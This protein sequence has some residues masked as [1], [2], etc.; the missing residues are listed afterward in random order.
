MKQFS[1]WHH[2]SNWCCEVHLNGWPVQG[3]TRYSCRK[4]VAYKQGLNP[5]FSTTALCVLFC[6]LKDSDRS[7][8]REKCI[9]GSGAPLMKCLGSYG[10]FG[11]TNSTS[12][13][14]GSLIFRTGRGP[15]L[16]YRKQHS[17]M[18]NKYSLKNVLQ[19]R[20]ERTVKVPFS[21]V[22]CSGLRP[23]NMTFRTQHFWI[24]GDRTKGKIGTTTRNWNLC[25]V[26]NKHDKWVDTTI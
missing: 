8:I 26:I 10:A 17:K 2:A 1:H 19:C 24:G 11:G 3:H 23:D 5:N 20:T 12:L 15:F 14:I 22:L 16:H 18:L 13:S 7:L 25:N 9:P 6:S 4:Q 21:V